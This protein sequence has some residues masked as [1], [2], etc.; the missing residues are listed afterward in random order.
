MRISFLKYIIVFIIC[1]FFTTDSYGQNEKKPIF[2]GYGV[3]GAVGMN[4]DFGEDGSNQIFFSFVVL[5]YYVDFSINPIEPT[6]HRQIHR[7]TSIDGGY[8]IF[9]Y[10]NTLYVAP[11]IGMTK[12]EILCYPKNVVENTT[13]YDFGGVICYRFDKY[14]AM[15]IKITNHQFGFTFGVAV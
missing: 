2:V 11:I 15:C 14:V 8:F 4:N 1:L 10:N 5:N 3:G 9:N 13:K 6:Q 12:N 7:V